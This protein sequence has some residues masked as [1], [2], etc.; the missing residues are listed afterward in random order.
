[1]DK[2]HTIPG[3]YQVLQNVAN[4]INYSEIINFHINKEISGSPTGLRKILGHES[5]ADRFSGN[6]IQIKTPLQRKSD[7]FMPKYVQA[8]IDSHV[9]DMGIM[10]F[11]TIAD[12][13]YK[14]NEVCDCN[15][16]L[17]R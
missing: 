4:T 14:L 11:K 2:I 7:L 15:L 17:V 8:A 9:K 5:R 6:Q 10:H 13:I 3:M 12:V 1:M 16:N